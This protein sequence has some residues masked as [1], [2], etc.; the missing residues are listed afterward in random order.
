MQRE[1]QPPVIGREGATTTT[2]AGE[3]RGSE[4]IMALWG[5]IKVPVRPTSGREAGRAPR[6]LH[7]HFRVAEGAIRIQVRDEREISIGGQ[8]TS[9]PDVGDLAPEIRGH[10]LPREDG[11]PTEAS[12]PCREL[13]I[14][15]A[16][17]TGPAT[18]FQSDWTAV[19]HPRVKSGPCVRKMRRELLAAM[20]ARVRTSAKMASR[21][22]AS[23]RARMRRGIHQ[24]ARATKLPRGPAQRRER[25]RSAKRVNRNKRGRRP[26][27]KGGERPKA[28]RR[29]ERRARAAPRAP[30]ACHRR[31]QGAF[32]HQ[33]GRK[34]KQHCRR[35]RPAECPAPAYPK[36]GL[37]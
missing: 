16:M 11:M 30:A 27:M 2:R 10:F 3:T 22:L 18:S 13:T 28:D 29:E 23:P 35:Q 31:A 8:T 1:A 25:E 26:L 37:R 15:G 9:S 14:A 19:R 12:V 33:K 17:R 20:C 36:R 4:D 34:G 5:S 24:T 32:G 7:Q 6:A 21:T